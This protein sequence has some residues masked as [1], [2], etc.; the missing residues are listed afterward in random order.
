MCNF[1]L[2]SYIINKQIE[3]EM[4]YMDQPIFYNWVY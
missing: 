2:Q 3:F 4:L 1:I